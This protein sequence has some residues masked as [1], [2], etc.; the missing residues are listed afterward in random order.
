M[1]PALFFKKL[2]FTIFIELVMTAEG[3]EATVM[4]ASASAMMDA[5]RARDDGRAGG[6]G[7][8]IGHDGHVVH[9]VPVL[10][11]QTVKVTQGSRTRGDAT[12]ESYAWLA[13]P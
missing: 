8:V 7:V 10:V 1:Y 13:S 3:W 11:A 6:A 4:E 12:R 9:L 5:S 2:N